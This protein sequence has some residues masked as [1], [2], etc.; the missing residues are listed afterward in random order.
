MWWV[1][2]YVFAC[3]WIFVQS[4]CSVPIENSCCDNC[5]II[6][7]EILFSS[8]F[9]KISTSLHTKVSGL[10]PLNL[11]K[12]NFQIDSIIKIHHIFLITTSNNNINV[13][14]LPTYQF[15][16]QYQFT[17]PA[18]HPTKYKTKLNFQIR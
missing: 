9:R 7:I 11:N 4:V 5:V 6:Y 13:S 8:L 12:T 15:T 14:H 1:L 16:Y 3:E 17:L 10:I 18:S 2:I